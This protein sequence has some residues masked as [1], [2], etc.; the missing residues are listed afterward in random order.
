MYIHFD[1]SYHNVLVKLDVRN[2]PPKPNVLTQ[3]R[4]KELKVHTQ[5]ENG[6][7]FYI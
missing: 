6:R 5:F 7:V 2:F 1:S 4:Q 3:K